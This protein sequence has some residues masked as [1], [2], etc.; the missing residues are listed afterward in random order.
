LTAIWA[1]RAIRAGA[2]VLLS[3]GAAPAQTAPPRVYVSVNG[4]AQ[5]AGNGFAERREFPLNAETATIAAQ[6]PFER[7]AVF[8]GG[9]GVRLWKRFGAGLSV[10]YFS[11]GAGAAVTARLPHPFQFDADREISGESG[12]ARRA[13]TGL[14]VQLLYMP[15]ARGRFRGMLFAGP[16]YLSAKQDLVRDVRYHEAFPY[17]TATFASAGLAR[18]TG[19]GFGFNAGVDACWMLTRRF[20][21]G[22]LVRVTRAAVDLDAAENR[23]V[24][25]DAGGVH[26]AIGGRMVF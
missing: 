20:G 10:S 9:A 2:V 26:V 6:H 13:E 21:A 19:S 3:A 12:R 1:L 15:P 25:I 18:A 7:G 5:A 24:A 22:A 16:S 11:A 17:D 8:D 23:R 4:G 14:H